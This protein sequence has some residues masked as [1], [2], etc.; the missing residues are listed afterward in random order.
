MTPSDEALRA[1]LYGDLA[2]I[3]TVRETGQ[4]KRK[5]TETRVWGVDSPWLRGAETTE[6]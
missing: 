6:N 1:E 5:L 3:V 2:D 4:D